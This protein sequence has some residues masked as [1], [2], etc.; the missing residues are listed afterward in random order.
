ME[1]TRNLRRGSS[2]ADVYY[3]KDALFALGCYPDNTK[4]SIHDTF[5]ADTELAVFAFQR[6]HA[7][8]DGRP[9]AVD[10]V[11]GRFTWDAVLAALL[12]EASVELPPNIGQTAASAIAPA[13]ARATG[14]R[15][16]IVLDALSYAY[17]P[18]VPRDYP[19]SLYIRGANLYASNGEPSIITAARIELGARNQPQYYSG[20]RKRMMLETIQKHPS[21]TGADC[22]GG[23][24]GLLRK[25]GHV[26]GRFDQTA[27]DLCSKAHSE[28]IAQ[29]ELKSGDWVGYSGHIGLYAGG[30]YAVE[31]LGGAYGCQLTRLDN[32][33]GYSFVDRQS[34]SK[35]DWTRFRRPKYY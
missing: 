35:S 9:L 4:K 6:A 27:N 32:R 23:I 28:A 26:A 18:D 3:M 25:F 1:F 33:R 13:L 30:G 14:K 12:P 2:G 10:G 21:T 17:D 16:R 24:V 19:L 34:H 7:D 22:S 31:W 20:G 29:S 5:D 15:Q 8:A 11:I